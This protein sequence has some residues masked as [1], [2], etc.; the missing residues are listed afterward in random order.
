MNEFDQETEISAELSPAGVF[1]WITGQRFKSL[2]GENMSNNIDFDHDCY[3]RN[4]AHK[5]C[6]PDET[7]ELS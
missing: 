6:F 5:L 3:L 1:G 4:P 7:H 2:T